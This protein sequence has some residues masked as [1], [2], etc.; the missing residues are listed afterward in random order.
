MNSLKNREI[1]AKIERSRGE[2]PQLL[3]E[4]LASA[5]LGLSCASLRKGRS[6]GQRGIR[7]VMPPYVRV[8]GRV[9]Y[10]RTDLDRWLNGLREFS[11]LAE[12]GD[13]ITEAGDL[14]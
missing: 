2:H 5:Y 4:K 10:R 13:V 11:N 7:T 3:T 6:E 1:P 12:E 9:F 8:G 14:I